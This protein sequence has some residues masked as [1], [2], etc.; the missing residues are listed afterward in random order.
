MVLIVLD[1]KELPPW[2]ISNHDILRPTF[3]FKR[4]MCGYCYEFQV[5]F[6]FE[7][8]HIGSPPIKIGRKKIIDLITIS[9]KQL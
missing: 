9:L 6:Y 7:F 8:D 1:G 3:A 4:K 2:N 5:D